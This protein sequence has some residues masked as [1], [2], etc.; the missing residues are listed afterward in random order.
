MEYNNISDYEKVIADK[1]TRVECGDQIFYVRLAGPLNF[2]VVEAM[3]NKDIPKE[4]RAIKALCA[5]LCDSKGLGLFDA[6]NE[7]HL[8]IVKEFG[9][10]EVSILTKT[11]WNF[12]DKKK[13]SAAV[14]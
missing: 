7:L 9:F 12:F 11:I 10:E 5:C 3:S 6:N 14:S 1:V 8:K 4:D 2:N 13:E